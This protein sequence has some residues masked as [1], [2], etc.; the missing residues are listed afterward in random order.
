[1]PRKSAKLPSSTARPAASAPHEQRQAR[2]FTLLL[3]VAKLI[4]AEGEFLCVLRDVSD[5]GL[6]AKLFHPLATPETCE[7][8]LGSGV[9]YRLQRVWQ[10][11]DH[12][13]FRFADGPLAAQQLI[14]ETGPFPKRHVRLRLARPVPVLLAANRVTLP[15]QLWDISQH[16][17]AVLLDQRLAIGLELRIDALH[18]PALIARVRWRRGGLHGLVFQQGFRLDE[19]AQLSCLLQTG[20]IKPVVT[21][22]PVRKVAP[23]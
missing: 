5:R 11:E 2:R 16:G 20:A 15:A 17:A 19:L 21:T 22:T 3:R 12:A 1:M 8:E 6:R 18:L 10:R 13:G 4:T 23:H 9:R 14:E 7:L